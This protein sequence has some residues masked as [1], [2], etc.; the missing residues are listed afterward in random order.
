MVAS[1]LGWMDNGM[2]PRYT[3]R[4]GG[5]ESFDTERRGVRLLRI[6]RVERPDDKTLRIAHLVMSLGQAR[7]SRRPFLACERYPS[8][9]PLAQDRKRRRFVLR[10]GIF[11]FRWA[12]LGT[13][14]QTMMT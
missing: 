10:I 4:G 1:C 5:V 8:S 13:R 14:D 11:G 9:I 3:R 6:R 2:I 7:I 12:S